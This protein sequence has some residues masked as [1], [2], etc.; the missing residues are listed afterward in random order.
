MWS[1]LPRPGSTALPLHAIAPTRPLPHTKAAITPTSTPT[2]LTTSR[3]VPRSSL[4]ASRPRSLPN[5]PETD[6]HAIQ[7]SPPKSSTALTAA[8][9]WAVFSL[10]RL[11]YT[12]PL[13]F[14][15]YLSGAR[16][17][18][19][20]LP[21]QI[22]LPYHGSPSPGDGSTTIRAQNLNPSHG[23]AVAARDHPP[24][25]PVILTRTPDRT[26]NPTRKRLLPS[27]AGRR[28]M[29]SPPCATLDTTATL[30][31]PDNLP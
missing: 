4:H 23:N 11:P 8:S 13:R 27:R 7:E 15:L 25:P 5:L 24:P 9:L 1:H 30:L 26:C 3:R 12:R 28:L 14:I 31:P 19:R 2:L 29:L 6:E 21:I 18:A 10:T 22:S 17:Q 20:S 16:L